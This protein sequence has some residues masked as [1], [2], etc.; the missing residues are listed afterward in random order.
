MANPALAARTKSSAFAPERSG[1]VANRVISERPAD[2]Y[3]ENAPHD[4]CI[5]DQG[6][7]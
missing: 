7:C 2:A 4:V 6:V 3:L 1:D 5:L